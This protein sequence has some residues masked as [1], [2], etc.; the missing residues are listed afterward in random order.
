MNLLEVALL[1]WTIVGGLAFCVNLATMVLD[2]IE[3]DYNND[4]DYLERLDRDVLAQFADTFEK[5]GD[6]WVPV[7]DFDKDFYIAK[8]SKTERKVKA[9][10]ELDIK[11]EIYKSLRRIQSR[12][13]YRYRYIT[14]PR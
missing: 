11:L 4:E 5:I 13:T 9:H 12:P 8:E 10:K 14:A 2:F 6:E 3:D 7:I 1:V